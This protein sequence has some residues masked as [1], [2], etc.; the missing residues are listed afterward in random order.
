[1]FIR[2]WSKPFPIPSSSTEV[3]NISLVPFDST[4]LIHSESSSP[5]SSLPELVTH[6]YLFLYLT[7]SI[8]T[9]IVEDPKYFIASSKN[10]GFLMMELFK[11]TLSAPDFNKYS[12]SF[13]LITPPQLPMG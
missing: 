12:I 9:I 11:K 5:E 13:K 1:M 2:F 6:I 4:F 10:L 3:T 7:V 8:E